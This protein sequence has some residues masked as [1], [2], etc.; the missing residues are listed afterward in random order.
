VSVTEQHLLPTR[1]PS[2]EVYGVQAALLTLAR[3]RREH[4]G[5]VWKF[6]LAEGLLEQAA[7][8]EALAVKWNA[9]T[10]QLQKS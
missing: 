1:I 2:P 6:A 7:K 5:R 4:Y 9:V 8:A 10:Q 3:E